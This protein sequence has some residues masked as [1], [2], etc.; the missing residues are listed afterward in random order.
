M[1][2]MYLF[3]YFFLTIT[4]QTMS[5]TNF[6]IQGHRGC[7][8]LLPENTIPAFLRAIDEGV[9]TIELDVV[10]SKDKKVVVS[11]EPDFNP[12]IS[13]TPSGKF[14]EKGKEG[15]LYQ[16]NY[17]QIKKYDVG[18]RGNPSFPEQQKMAAHKPLLVDV[19]KSVEKYTKQQHL[20]PV[21]YNIEIKSLPS[22]YGITQP[23]V[24]EFSALVYAIL[25]KH[26][27]AERVCVQS[28]DF[29]VMR[30]WNFQIETG[31][32]YPVTL[33]VLIEPDDDNDIKNNLKKLGFMPD[34]WSPYFNTLTAER[35]LELHDLGIRVIPWTVNNPEDMKK[36]IEMGC[37]GL[38][39]DY[40]NRTKTL[41]E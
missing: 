23:N 25:K 2:K 24:E 38:I 12:N 7:R 30:F 6:E 40:P 14:V 19:I 33:S 3:I 21:K 5:Q 22:E 16:L 39:T 8:G 26:L 41:F 20:L 17:R 13:T 31:N 18:L 27:P 15:N 37:D 35:V 29:N 10:I 9:Q 4:F 28:F 36:V 32:Y 11:H 34:V 1:K